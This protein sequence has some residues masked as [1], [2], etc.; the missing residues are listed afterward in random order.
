MNPF[1]Q[2]NYLAK[3]APT[4]KF[5]DSELKPQYTTPRIQMS[6]FKIYTTIFVIGMIIVQGIIIFLVIGA[7]IGLIS[8]LRFV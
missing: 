2:A 6:G 1:N 3:Y 7:V 5:G 4:I 8:M